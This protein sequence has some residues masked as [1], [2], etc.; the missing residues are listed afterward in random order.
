MTLIDL[1]MVTDL[2]TKVAVELPEERFPYTGTADVVMNDL[3]TD[4][5]E[6]IVSEVRLSTVYKAIYISIE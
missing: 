3:S 1:L 2:D 4:N 6:R 5:L